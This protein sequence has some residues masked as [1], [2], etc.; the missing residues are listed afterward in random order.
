[1]TNPF[2]D[3]VAAKVARDKKRKRVGQWIGL[4]LVLVTLAMIL[5]V[6]W[7]FFTS[8]NALTVM[9]CGFIIIA[10]LIIQYAEK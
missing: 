8:Q 7:L 6:L 4:T 1:M 2:G 9:R 5:A 3:L 10:V